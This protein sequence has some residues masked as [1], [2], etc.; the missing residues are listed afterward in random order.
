M[1]SKDTM[2]PVNDANTIHF[3]WYYKFAMLK[4]GHL[5][6]RQKFVFI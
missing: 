3:V 5:I 1:M 6:Y 4:I 2:L